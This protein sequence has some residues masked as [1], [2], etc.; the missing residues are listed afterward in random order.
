MPWT[1][2]DRQRCFADEDAFINNFCTEITLKRLRREPAAIA[3]ARNLCQRLT[4]LIPNA[5]LKSPDFADDQSVF[6]SS[7]Y[8]NKNSGDF[9]GKSRVVLTYENNQFYIGFQQ[10]NA[11]RFIDG[12]FEDA[13]TR[14]VFQNHLAEYDFAQSTRSVNH[15]VTPIS[16]I[17]NLDE[18]P[19]THPLADGSDLAQALQLINQLI[20]EAHPPPQE[21]LAPRHLPQGTALTPRD[22]LP[23]QQ[24]P[25]PV[26][27]P[28][29]GVTSMSKNTILFGPP[30]TGK[31]FSTVDQAL[32][33]LG[34]AVSEDRSEA[35]RTFDRA[36]DQG[37]VVFTTFHQSYAYEDFIE[38]I[39][40][41][42]NDQNK[43]IYKIRNGTFKQLAR[44]AT[45]YYLAKL[46]DYEE[47]EMLE[48]NAR[49][50]ANTLDHK[51][52]PEL[53][54]LLDVFWGNYHEAT[55][56]Q[57]KDAANAARR[58]VLVI[59]EINRGNIAKVFG[60]LI[61]LIEETKRL[62]SGESLPV[63]LPYSGELFEVPGNLCLLGTMN[64]ADRSLATLDVA[65]RRRFYFEELMPDPG[66]L[67]DVEIPNINLSQWLI[68]LNKR[69]QAKRGREFTIGHA[70]F[71]GLKPGHRDVGD[72]P[73][74][75]NLGLV[76]QKQILPLLDE[77][78][79]EDWEGIR[80][81]LGENG[82]SREPQNFVHWEE[83]QLPSKSS[84]TKPEKIYSWNKGA[85]IQ[86]QAYN[87]LVN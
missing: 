67:E 47:N 16:P 25:V 14:T 79:F 34:K 57:R 56:K 38:G 39:R 46:S 86:P 8:I 30:G 48:A 40:V 50:Y 1:N 33:M 53:K 13:A 23:I 26:V 74:I 45:F 51:L 58:F 22:F 42:T 27:E 20:F 49:V 37:S 5:A 43:P 83:V 19:E 76:M 18:I 32:L 61:T 9:D 81:V 72:L 10:R 71:M 35:K 70:F 87:K 78:F 2:A 3:A 63:V 12:C 52:S 62:G 44:K 6:L 68:A 64:T 11:Q 69:I 17:E 29:A 55:D 7:G 75:A 65:L 85:L 59:D 28:V 31:T 73:T 82:G 15:V 54:A 84:L 80:F 60:E 77:Y 24:Q 41:E 36:I 21:F 66:L 4:V